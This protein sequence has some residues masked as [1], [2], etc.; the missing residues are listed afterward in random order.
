VCREVD[1]IR[2][3][4]T[5]A[6][7]LTLVMAAIW[8]VEPPVSVC[9]GEL[10]SGANIPYG[11]HVAGAGGARTRLNYDLYDNERDISTL[12]RMRC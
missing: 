10:K 9:L 6:R 11:F 7:L 4:A 8:K 1:R 5:A 3:E 12:M 2:A